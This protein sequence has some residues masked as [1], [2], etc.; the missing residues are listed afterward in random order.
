MAETIFSK[1]INREIPA[2]I[3]YEDDISLAFRD[4]NP[5]APVHLLIIPKKDIATIND[6]GKDDR[7]LVGHLYWVA[8]ELAREMGFADHGYRT[9]MNCGENSGQTVFHIHLHLLA[10]KPLG[11]PP[12]TDKMK[13]A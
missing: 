6:I 3:V 8:G 5:Q 2:D 9:V 11:W 13:Q 7:E 12:Y 1:I 10:G 4:I